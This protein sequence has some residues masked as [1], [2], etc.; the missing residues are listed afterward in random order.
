MKAV[1]EGEEGMQG[2]KRQHR[3]EGKGKETGVECAYSTICMQ[4]QQLCV[5]AEKLGILG[6]HFRS[7][8]HAMFRLTHEQRMCLV[9]RGIV[10]APSPAHPAQRTG[11]L[12]PIP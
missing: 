3:Q 2:S 7:F 8:D 5:F 6:T 11:V 1:G 9:P 12:Q 4:E 10:P